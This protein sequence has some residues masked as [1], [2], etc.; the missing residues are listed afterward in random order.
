MVEDALLKEE[1]PITRTPELEPMPPMLSP[2]LPSVVEAAL[3]GDFFDDDDREPDRRDEREKDRPRERKP[4]AESTASSSAKKR[5]VDSESLKSTR[6]ARDAKPAKLSKDAVIKDD[7]EV[8]KTK[9]AAPTTNRPAATSSTASKTLKKEKDNRLG[10]ESPPRKAAPK[11]KPELKSK[12]PLESSKSKASEGAKSR[13]Q[14]TESKPKSRPAPRPESR[15]SSEEPLQKRSSGQKKA[16]AASKSLGPRTLLVRI[17]IP[18]SLRQ[19]VAEIFDPPRPP[20]AGKRPAPTEKED[21]A[22]PSKRPK[23]AE[24]AQPISKSTPRAAISTP[25]PGTADSISTPQKRRVEGRREEPR[26]ETPGSVARL[27]SRKVG[28]AAHAQSKIFMEEYKKYLTKGTSLKHEAEGKGLPREEIE[29]LDPSTSLI[30]MVD[31]VLCYVIAFASEEESNRLLNRPIGKT[32]MSLLP[33]LQFA[34]TRAISTDKGRPIFG[35][36]KS[37][38]AWVCQHVVDISTPLIERM[39]RNEL[40]RMRGSLDSHSP[41][42]SLTP[43]NATDKADKLQQQLEKAHNDFLATLRVSRDRQTQELF[44]PLKNLAEA[45]AA[46]TQDFHLEV[47]ISQ[48]PQTWRDRARSPEKVQERKFEPGKYSSPYLLPIGPS[49]TVLE[50]VNIGYAVLSEWASANGVEFKRRIR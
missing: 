20:K 38:T 4:A 7:V 49:S 22:P 23:M 9:K 26:V 11:A 39:L 3:R 46:A 48:F 35:L 43:I 15:S 21:L 19:Q 36:L 14:D 27:D 34:C 12:A 8:K 32:W 1:T 37:I 44:I 41:E 40:E 45:R 31:G 24:P 30:K 17:R 16:V 25:R 28:E 2:T 6:D 50:V 29:A 47:L 42:E 18:S 5:D 33:L 13:Q 10:S